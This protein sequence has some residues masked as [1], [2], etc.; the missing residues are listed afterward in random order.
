MASD[1]HKRYAFPS[2]LRHSF[3]RPNHR[4]GFIYNRP[5]EIL[6]GSLS[7]KGI[8][9]VQYKDDF[10]EMALEIEELELKLAP[11]SSSSFMDL[12]SMTGESARGFS[13]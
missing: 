4:L 6:E 12:F 11:Q 13:R 3:A 9:H 8:H 10:V 1:L 2:V 5:P 7:K